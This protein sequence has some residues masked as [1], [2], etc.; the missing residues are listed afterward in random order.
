MGFLGRLHRNP[1]DSSKVG[2]VC[3]DALLRICAGGDQPQ[4]ASGAL[5]EV[6]QFFVLSFAIYGYLTK[7]NQALAKSHAQTVPI[8]TAIMTLSGI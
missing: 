2:A 6:K 8:I 3:V 1:G 5:P 7:S 4:L